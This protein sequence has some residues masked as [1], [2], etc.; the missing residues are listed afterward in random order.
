[1]LK[2][3]SWVELLLSISL[4]LVALWAGLRICE[5]RP[6]SYDCEAWFILGVNL[7]LPVGSL[8]LV[9]SVWSLKRG[10]WCPQYGFVAG[11]LAVMAYWW[12]HA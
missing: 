2:L 5:G 7:F 6:Y 4:L 3:L 8:G 1:M 10:S 12:L 11:C 9:C